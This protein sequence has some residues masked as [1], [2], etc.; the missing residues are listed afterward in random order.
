M[1]QL[2]T[3]RDVA[4]RPATNPA[5][6]YLAGLAPG[7]RRAQAAALEWLA[8]EATGG[9]ACAASMPWGELRFEHTHAL[10]ARLEERYAP[11]TANRHLAALRGVLLAARRLGQIGVEAHALAS[12]LEP[13]RGS[14]LPAG[15]ALGR[16]ELERLFRVCTADPSPAGY[17]D[18]ALLAVL[19]GCGLRRAEAAALELADWNGAEL[20]VV[21]KGRKERCVPV[22]SGARPA[23]DAW[24]R[25]RG[26]AAGALLCPVDRL[27]VVSV[28]RMSE[29]AIYAALA[30]RARRAEVAGFSPHDLRRTY[31]SEL[32]D[33]GVDLPTVQ[34][35]V[36]H[37]RPETTAR[38]DRRGERTRRAGVE[39]LPIPRVTRDGAPGQ[40]AVGG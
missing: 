36:G 7:S 1:H 10:R 29:Q 16:D 4:H 5:A 18:A 37:A 3:P 21:G 25:A 38:Y 35:L 12:D 27:G 33:A 9:A 19:F 24:V 15:R 22:P 31:T 23:L 13:V 14:R 40:H 2:E 6:A 20:R 26:N 8:A 17:R 11:A 28:R 32:L 30:R 34:A 39:L